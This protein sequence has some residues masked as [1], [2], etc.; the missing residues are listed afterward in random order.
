MDKLNIHHLQRLPFTHNIVYFGFVIEDHPRMVTVAHKD[1]E[2]RVSIENFN[3][4]YDTTKYPYETTEPK[5]EEIKEL[6]K[7]KFTIVGEE[8]HARFTG[9]SDV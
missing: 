8:Q 4:P 7:D 9:S 3:G 6:V 1:N 2:L 5:F